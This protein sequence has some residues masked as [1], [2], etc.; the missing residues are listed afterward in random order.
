[1]TS[2]RGRCKSSAHSM[3]ATGGSGDRMSRVAG[4][5]TAR[6]RAR[7]RMVEQIKQEALGQL[8]AEGAAGLSLRQIARELGLVSSGLYRYFASREEL[9]TALILDAYA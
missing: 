1:M 5:H 6:A 9:L 7:V 2:G 8:T 3:S 4:P